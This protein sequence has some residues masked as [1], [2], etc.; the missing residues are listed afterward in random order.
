MER[1]GVTW[2]DIKRDPERA[3]EIKESYSYIW[4]DDK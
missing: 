2:E 4:E 3:G 1:E